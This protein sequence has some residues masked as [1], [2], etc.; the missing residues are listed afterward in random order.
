MSSVMF[1]MYQRN[2]WYAA[3]KI[4]KSFGKKLNIKWTMST[5]SFLLNKKYKSCK[6]FPQEEKQKNSTWPF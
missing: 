3:L 6:T 4:L 1:Q 5:L 2:S